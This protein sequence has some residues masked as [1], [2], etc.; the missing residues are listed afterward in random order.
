MY[1]DYTTLI[2]D[3]HENNVLVVSRH[4]VRCEILSVIEPSPKINN[5]SSVCHLVCYTV[6]VTLHKP[7]SGIYWQRVNIGRLRN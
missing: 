1:Y 6:D 5:Q 4:V 7:H 2:T 3:V